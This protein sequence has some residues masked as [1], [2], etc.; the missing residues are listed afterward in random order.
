MLNRKIYLN[1]INVV[2]NN[3]AV[4][5]SLKAPWQI[6]V[7]SWPRYCLIWPRF[8]YS[9]KNVLVFFVS[10]LLIFLFTLGKQ[11]YT[12]NGQGEKQVET[13]KILNIRIKY[14]NMFIFI[15]V[16]SQFFLKKNDVSVTKMF[17]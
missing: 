12:I 8:T 14:L 1:V 17:S 3:S 6:S 2:F 16:F 4:I 10:T 7:S 15:S 5:I 11:T 13:L 9:T